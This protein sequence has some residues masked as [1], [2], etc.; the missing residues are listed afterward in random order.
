MLDDQPA[1]KQ[2]LLDLENRMK[3]DRLQVEER[4]VSRMRDMPGH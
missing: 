4:L 2:D 1:T 3:A